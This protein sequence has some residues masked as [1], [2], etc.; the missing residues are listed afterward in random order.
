[1]LY[2]AE[3]RAHMGCFFVGRH[4]ASRSKAV[5]QKVST[6]D[7]CRLFIRR[8]FLGHVGKETISLFRDGAILHAGQELIP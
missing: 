7:R 6:L 5:V 3:L 2:P 1:M 4:E 8:L